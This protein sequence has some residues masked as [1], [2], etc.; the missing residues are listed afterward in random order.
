MADDHG[1]WVRIYSKSHWVPDTATL[2][3]WVGDGRLG[4]NDLVWDPDTSQ[5]IRSTDVKKLRSQFYPFEPIQTRWR[6]EAFLVV[7]PF[8]MLMF[9]AVGAVV[10]A[11]TMDSGLLSTIRALTWKK[12]E[13]R[14]TRSAMPAEVERF[15]NGTTRTR[16]R[17]NFQYEYRLDRRRY[18]SSR[19]DFSAGAVD[20]KLLD[21]ADAERVVGRYPAG[22]RLAVYFDPG[23]PASAVLDRGTGI[24]MGFFIGIGMTAVA[25]LVLVAWWRRRRAIARVRDSM[26]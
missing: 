22:R 17:V 26:K 7:W 11:A 8:M 2:R 13:G 4:R 12:T 23:E 15:G 19:V 6:Y 24:I 20:N 10:I 18:E 16:Y 25:T 14:I 9:G 1:W 21:Y 5:W 3:S